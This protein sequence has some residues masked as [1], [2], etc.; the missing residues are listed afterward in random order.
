MS[1]RFIGFDLETYDPF[2]KKRGWSWKYGAGKVLCYGL[3]SKEEGANV[4]HACREDPKACGYIESILTD[5]NVTLVGANIIYDLGWTMYDLGWTDTYKIKCRVYD[6][7]QAEHILDEFGH[8]TLESVSQHYLHKGKVTSRIEEWVRKNVKNAKGDFRAYLKDAPWELLCEYVT[9]DVMNPIEIMAKQIKRLVKEELAERA[10]LEFDCNLPTLQMTINGFPFDNEQ[11]K[12]NCA[13]LKEFTK[14]YQKSFGEKYGMQGFNPNSSKQIAKLCDMYGIPYN[15]KITL[16]GYNGRNFASGA[17]KDSACMDAKRIVSQMRLVKG[18]PVAMVPVSLAERTCDLLK[19]NGFI[20]SCS[21]SCDKKFFASARNNYEVIGI[22]ADWKLCN[23]ILSK[24]LDDSYAERFVCPD[25]R[26]RPQFNITNTKSFRFSSCFCNIQQVP[27]KGG[28]YI[29][30]KELED[31]RAHFPNLA[32]ALSHD[33]KGW[34]IQ[35]APLTRGL[36]H[37][38]DDRVYFKIDYGQIEYR[39]IANIAVGESGEAV[40][41]KYAENPRLDYHQYVIDLTG[42]PRKLA[43]NMNFGVAFGMSEKSMCENF[44]W[45]EER[46]HEITEQYHT[47]MPFV[48]PTLQLVGDVAVKR[49]YIKTVLGSHARL[50]DKN[51]KYTMLNRYTQGSGAEIMKTAIVNIY[52]AGLFNV[53]TFHVTVHDELGAS[54]PATIQGAE[55]C[56]EVQRIMCTSVPLRVPLVADI[57]C[58]RDWYNVEEPD[59][60]EEPDEVVRAFIDCLKEV[61]A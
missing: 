48:A 53:L 9:G 34:S 59:D 21:P 17:E 30:D 49:G 38:E 18:E 51:K 42:L 58:G 5:P 16:K 31:V 46:G 27:S 15:C 50:P 57:E 19:E 47:A 29:Q 28:I 11:R 60:W 54:V 2:L 13:E 55:A 39:L 14:Q 10:K 20:V 7:L 12:K 32:K 44:G 56:L 41:A 22:V 36:F 33:D 3:Y 1:R 40:R 45:D 4:L 43:K 26:I 25:G 8:H 24:L 61:A 37:A 23:G 52:K 35:F 6:V